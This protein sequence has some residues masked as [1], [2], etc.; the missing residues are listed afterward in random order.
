MKRILLVIFSFVILLT[1]IIYNKNN[2][3]TISLL[4]TD[5]D[6]VEGNYNNIFRYDNITFKELTNSIKKND[7]IIVKNKRIFLNQLIFKA[8]NIVLNIN[9]K[10]YD[11]RCNSKK[12]YYYNEYIK[13]DIINL[14]SYLNKITTANIII[15]TNNCSFKYI[16]ANINDR[17]NNVK[18]I[19]TVNNDLIL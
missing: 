17:Y 4:I 2:R 13:K 6:I 10:E 16:K 9:N 14:I 1:I 3:E 8:D 12:D 18:V 11:K 7:S 5:Q 15:E 19:N